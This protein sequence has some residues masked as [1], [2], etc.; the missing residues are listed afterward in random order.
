[1]YKY[2]FSD[3]DVSES[4]SVQQNSDYF[5]LFRFSAKWDPVPTMLCQN[6]T[7]IIKGFMGQS[8]AFR[9]DRIKKDVM[10]LGELA[11]S[12]EARYIH[13]EFGKGFWTFYG[14]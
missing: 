5:T 12:T 4:R 13:S 1:P 8:T 7:D 6:H 3:I 11:S 10:I 9:K 14:G 2:E